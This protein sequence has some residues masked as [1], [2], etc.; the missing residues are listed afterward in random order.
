MK[1]GV[2][3]VNCARGGLVDEA[4]LAEALKSGQVAGAA[5]DV[6]VEEPATAE[7]AVQPAQRGV[8]A[9]SRRRHQRGAGKRRAAGR[10]ADVGLSAAR[11][12]LQRGQ[13][14]LDHAPRRRR[15]CKPF[16]A[17]AEKLGSFAGQLTEDPIKEVHITYEGAVAQMKI[18]ALTSAV[19]VRAAA[20]DARRRQR[21]VGAGGGARARHGGRGNHPRGRRR[22]RKPDHGHGGDRSGR[23]AR[24]RAPCSPTAARASS[25]SRASAWTPSSARR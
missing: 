20:A 11:R 24:C 17:L 12:D 4:A 23:R 7:P 5:F 3:I 13:F 16:I 9:A 21:G 8:H 10:R 22:L 1:K 6:F 19:L 25:T 14:P 2:R 18:K 15:S